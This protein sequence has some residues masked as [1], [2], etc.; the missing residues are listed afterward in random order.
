M[1]SGHMNNPL[2]NSFSLV[3]FRL[4]YLIRKGE[5]F[6]TNKTQQTERQHGLVANMLDQEFRDWSS[7]SESTTCCKSLD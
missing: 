6:R 7:I 4:N 3:R 2:T 5:E 1:V